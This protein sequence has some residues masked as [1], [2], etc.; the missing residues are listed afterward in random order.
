MKIVFLGTP[1]FAVPSLDALVEAGHEICLVVTNPDRRKGRGNTLSPPAVK[2]AAERHGLPVLQIESVKSSGLRETLEELKP[3]LGV[4]V[5]FGHYLPKSIRKAP[6]LGIINVHASLL[7][8]HRGAAPLSQA[9]LD[10][11][12]NYGVTIM[13]I[14]R[15]MDA[16]DMLAQ[17]SIPA[18]SHHTC[19]V[20]TELLSK[21]GGDVLAETVKKL[22]TEPMTT[23]KQDESLS[24]AVSK[25]SKSDGHIDWS[26]DGVYI[27]RLVR[28]M[29]PWPMTRF[30]FSGKA[31]TVEQASWEENQGSE[32]P[33]TVLA[34]SEDGMA[35]QTGNGQLI[36]KQLKPAGKSSMSAAAFARGRQLKVG[37]RLENG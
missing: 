16:G 20:L 22:E 10:G 26:Q 24:T 29:N 17:G 21:L 4:V 28:A 9:I 31:V 1:Q 2:V 34:I 13:K 25:L 12:A 8:R 30:Q 7:P 36:L 32:D 14:A 5:A 6:R 15:R 27:E 23:T 33:G 18:E 35:V 3:D 19:G 37:G 11:D